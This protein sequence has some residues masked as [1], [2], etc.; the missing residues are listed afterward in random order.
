MERKNFFAV[1]IGNSWYKALTSDEGYPCEYQIPNAFL[2]LMKS[3]M[4]AV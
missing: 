2:C 1:D 4:K 3:F